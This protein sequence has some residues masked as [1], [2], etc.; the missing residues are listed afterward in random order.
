MGTFVYRNGKI[1]PKE[2]AYEAES[3]PQIMRDISE[4]KS[5]ITGE[6][7]SSRSTHR[8]HLRQHN[9]V[10][11]GNDTSHMNKKREIPKTDERR[12]DL[13]SLLADKSDRQIRQMIRHDLKNRSQN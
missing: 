11:V 10:E 3:G 12:R 13:A 1:V 8:A 6:T 4:Y 7:I 5:M 2:E 9:C